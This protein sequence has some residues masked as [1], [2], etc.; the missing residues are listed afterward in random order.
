M[1]KIVIACDSYKGCLSSSEVARAAAEG[2]AEVYPDCEIVRLAVADGGE[3]TVD[4]LVDTLGGHLNGLKSLTLLP[5][6]QGS[7]GG[8]RKILPSLNPAAA[9]R[10]YASDQ[11]GS[12]NQLI[13]TTKG[14][15]D[16]N[17]RPREG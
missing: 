3:G 16:C 15:A 1:K 11:R 2:V 7:L 6:C 10:T 17:C 13:T 12:S 8:G 5:A 4:A 14:L 9:C